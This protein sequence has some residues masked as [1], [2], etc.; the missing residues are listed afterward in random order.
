[1]RGMGGDALEHVGQPGLRIDAVHLGGLC[2]APNYAERR[3]K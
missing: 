3:R 1:M 2:R